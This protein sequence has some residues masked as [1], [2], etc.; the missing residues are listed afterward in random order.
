MTSKEKSIIE[1]SLNVAYGIIKK[2]PN[3]KIK[4]TPE[5]ELLFNLE[6]INLNLDIPFQD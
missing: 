5:Y 6:N 3:S 4:G 2:L 1:N